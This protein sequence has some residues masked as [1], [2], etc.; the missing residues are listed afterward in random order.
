[1]ADSAVAARSS[2]MEPR[3][4]LGDTQ[5][6]PTW[7]AESASMMI[8]ADAC[9]QPAPVAAPRSEY[10]SDLQ[11]PAVSL[12]VGNAGGGMVQVPGYEAAQTGYSVGPTVPAAY[13]REMPELSDRPT[14]LTRHATEMSTMVSGAGVL[15]PQHGKSSD[16][17]GSVSTVHEFVYET[18]ATAGS[19]LLQPGSVRRRRTVN[20]GRR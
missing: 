19:E 5:R 9:R 16:S 12:S 11:R 4:P 15:Q 2:G 20:M 17:S 7:I 10:V 13:R 3:V 1:V 18:D 8:S 6:A 14:E